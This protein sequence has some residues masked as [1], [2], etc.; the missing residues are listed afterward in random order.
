MRDRIYYML[1]IAALIASITA[2]VLV[3]GQNQPTVSFQETAQGGDLQALFNAIATRV[4][5]DSQYSVR[6]RVSA[7]SDGTAVTVSQAGTRIAE[8]GANYFC[9]TNEETSKVCY[10]FT[11]L[12]AVSV[13]D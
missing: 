10:P 6:L 4:N 9:L 3:F 2:L 1:A 12:I 7:I 13:P 8:V 5:N 11:Q